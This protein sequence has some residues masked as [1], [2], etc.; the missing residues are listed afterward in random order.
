[1]LLVVRARSAMPRTTLRNINLLTQ[2]DSK[3]TQGVS[4]VW[5]ICIL[6]EQDLTGKLDH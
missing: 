1:M 5:K 3:S 6:R 4:V 2:Q